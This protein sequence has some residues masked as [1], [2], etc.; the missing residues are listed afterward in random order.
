MSFYKR[1]LSIS[2][3]I[4]LSCTSILVSATN[5]IIEVEVDEQKAII[6]TG[7]LDV[8][9]FGADLIYKITNVNGEISGVGHTKTKLDGNGN[10][11]FEFDKLLLPEIL[12]SGVY[13]VTVLG[14]ELDV[15]LTTNFEYY[16]PDRIL[17]IL[18]LIKKANG[19]V[20]TIITS[21]INGKKNA[22]ILSIDTT[23]YNSFDD[24]GKKAFETIMST[25]QYDL[26][27]SYQTEADINKIQVAFEEFLEKHNHAVPAGQFASVKTSASFTEWYDTYY[28]KL[29]FDSESD[30]TKI[31]KEVK[32]TDDF[33]KRITSKNEPLTVEQIKA[34]LYESAL[35]SGICEKTDSEV[36]EIILDFSSYFP[37][38]YASF[39]AL[40]STQKGTVIEAISGVSFDSVVEVAN[41][42]DRQVRL[43]SGGGNNNQGSGGSKNNGGGGSVTITGS[44]PPSKE[45]AN[46]EESNNKSENIIFNDMKEAVWAE[47]AISFLY[48]RGIIN[49]N[50][51]GSFK[52]NSNITR[53]EFVKMIVTAMD[54]SASTS[55][56]DFVDVNAD[57]WY[58]PYVAASCEWG[59]V[60]GDG[61]GYFSPEANITRQDMVT[62]L[63]RAL[64]EKGR[65]PTE[66]LSFTDNNSISDYAA[67]G[68]SYFSQINVINGFVDGS[69][70]PLKNATR[71]EVAMVFYKLITSVE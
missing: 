41:E 37:I 19:T 36:K 35:L 38:N 31:L 13:T 1:V 4:I 30:V 40:K 68:I 16:G 59:I 50:P 42:V 70:G 64:G 65:K 18:K 52:P 53:A 2:I 54:I 20:G 46:T 49:G 39:N 23:A 62:M 57:A 9:R 24:D 60:K 3:A 26:P 48:E 14:E 10:V 11:V 71:A 12:E 61:N 51:D 47:E 63:Y 67:D 66:K 5:N 58:A 56:I 45:N 7:S 17:D 22:D 44:V 21:E 25:A 43:V 29:G 27:D 15:P 32:D 55:D 6:V 28:V 34:Y 69:F 33:I 8:P